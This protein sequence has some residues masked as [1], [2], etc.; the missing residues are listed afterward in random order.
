ML[1]KQ[2]RN[3]CK[4]VLNAAKLEY[5]NRTKNLLSDQKVGSHDFWRIYNRVLHRGASTIPPLFNG[6][7]VLTSFKDKAELFAQIFSKNSNIDDFGP[8]L[9][10]FPVRTNQILD[11]VNFSVKTVASSISNLGSSKATGPDGILVIILQKCSPELSPIFTKLFKNISYR[12]LSSFLLE[13]SFYYSC[14]KMQEKHLTL[15][16]I[17]QLVFYR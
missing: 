9:P 7:E 11:H 6:P 1:F 5:G 3:H 14:L 16:T 13:T 10:D 15:I 4:Y 12:I 8:I 2:A 17:V